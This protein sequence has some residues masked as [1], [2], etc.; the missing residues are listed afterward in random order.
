MITA[1][2]VEG[3]VP[4]DQLVPVPQLPLLAP[5]YVFC[6]KTLFPPNT[7]SIRSK[8]LARVVLNRDLFSFSEK[9]GF[10]FIVG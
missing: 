3:T 6:P 1:S 10:D 8:H 7:K 5:V 2:P 9:V 4:P